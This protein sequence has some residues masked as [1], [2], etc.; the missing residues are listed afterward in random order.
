MNM[1]F[2]Y[3][4]RIPNLKSKLVTETIY[5]HAF[6]SQ[7]IF[8][9]IQLLIKTPQ[10]TLEHWACQLPFPPPPREG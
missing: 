7:A 6:T 5:T 1:F 3:Y 10:D 9:K 2:P 4:T 8:K